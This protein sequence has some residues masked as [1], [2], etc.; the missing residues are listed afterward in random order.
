VNDLVELKGAILDRAFHSGKNARSSLEG[1][2]DFLRAV[3]QVPSGREGS[4][5]PKTKKDNSESF[6]LYI[7]AVDARSPGSSR[8]ICYWCFDPGLAMLE[9]CAKG[10]RSVILTS[11]TLSPISVFAHDL[12]MYSH[13]CDQ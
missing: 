8:R 2:I 7:C 4:E 9:L 13:I 5:E 10:V 1:V 3:F 12:K 6:K 11:G